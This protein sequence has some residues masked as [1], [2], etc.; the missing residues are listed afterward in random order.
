MVLIGRKLEAIHARR[1]RSTAGPAKPINRSLTLNGTIKRDCSEQSAKVRLSNQTAGKPLRT[2]YTAETSPIIAASWRIRRFAHDT[3]GRNC[4]AEFI[5]SISFR[6]KRIRDLETIL[7]ND[8]ID[9]GFVDFIEKLNT[10]T[11]RAYRSN[12]TLCFEEFGVDEHRFV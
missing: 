3:G 10:I 4:R 1:S 8:P 7:F 2:S 9:H 6:E 12:T 11:L 5:Q